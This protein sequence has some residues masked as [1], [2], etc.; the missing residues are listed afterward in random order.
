MIEDVQPEEKP[1]QRRRILLWP[2]VVLT[3]VA[4]VA[5][6]F[7]GWFTVPGKTRD[8]QSI[9]RVGRDWADV[10]RELKA[11]GYTA[12]LTD[13]GNY[14]AA[15]FH[16]PFL[17]PRYPSQLYRRWPRLIPLVSRVIPRAWVL[18]TVDTSGTVTKAHL[19]PR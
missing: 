9:V 11:K 13:R 18:A 6:D 3:I 7:R 12:T 16:H 10:A 2:W 1:E 15:W 5:Y 8:L 17:I 14:A 4:L 19:R